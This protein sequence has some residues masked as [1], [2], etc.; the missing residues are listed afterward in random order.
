[1]LRTHIILYTPFY[2]Q[3]ILC[4][5]SELLGNSSAL[6]LEGSKLWVEGSNARARKSPECVAGAVRS[7]VRQ[8][9]AVT[10]RNGSSVNGHLLT[11]GAS[12]SESS[13]GLDVAGN[14]ASSMS[15]RERE[16]SIAALLG[17]SGEVCSR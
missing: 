10:W 14:S 8:S 7:R 4:A 5:P 3:N 13:A 12:S 11:R 1:M 17:S 16:E 15:L 2:T 6:L 9:R